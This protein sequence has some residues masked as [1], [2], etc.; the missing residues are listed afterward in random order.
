[1]ACAML[2]SVTIS[3]VDLH[4]LSCEGIYPMNTCLAG[5]KA[6]VMWRQCTLHMHIGLLLRLRFQLKCSSI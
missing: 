1:M 6:L 5:D 4:V 2:V 3:N